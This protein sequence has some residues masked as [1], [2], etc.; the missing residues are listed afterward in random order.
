MK[1]NAPPPA[2]RV[3]ARSAQDCP[4]PIASRAA[5][6][7]TAALRE[8]ADVLAVLP[9][10]GETLHAVMTGRYDLMQLL[11]ALIGQLGRCEIARYAT[12]SY[13]RKNLAEIIRLFDSGA[14]GKMTLLC[15][16]FFR[17]HNKDLWTET[18][19]EFRNRGQRAAASRSHCKVATLACAD[20]RKFVLE[21]SANLRT[22]SNKEQFCLTHDAAVSDWYGAWI[23]AEVSKHEGSDD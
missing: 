19:A 9:G 21:G 17:D 20:G 8:A 22:N 13:N 4:A 12:L 7:R 6:R 3:R 11:A 10:P 18:L 2:F 1:F 14:V 15:S 16:A 23:D 5:A